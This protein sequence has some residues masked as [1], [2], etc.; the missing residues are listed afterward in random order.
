MTTLAY[1][2]LG[3]VL[4]VILAVI[5]ILYYARDYAAPVP[6][7]V[8]GTVKI[9][10]VG[11]S[12]TYGV[13]V[14]D[15]EV[16]CY[17][18]QLEGLLGSGYSVRNF[19]V[20]GQSAQQSADKPY[21]K[22][23]HFKTSSD[24]APDIVLLM[25]GTNDATD[26][27]WQGI[28]PFIAD[29]RVLAD[30]YIS[31]PSRPEVYIMTPST[32]FPVENY[33]KVIHKMNNDRLDEITAALKKLAEELD[34]P[35]IDVNAAT[36]THLEFFCFDGLHPDAGGARLIAETAYEALAPSDS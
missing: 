32:Q 11:D 6:P 36:K 15:R 8:P 35:V 13:F 25:L 29:Y 27:N 5:L 33:T 30:H 26:R 34:L 17:P 14:S 23:K 19:G 12:I 3:L 22:N 18:A 21:R 16:N 1:I 28:D 20:N 9:A 2:I 31:L 4:L 24:F 10:C 7:A